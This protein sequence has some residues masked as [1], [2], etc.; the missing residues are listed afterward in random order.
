MSG[1]FT[2]SA[3]DLNGHTPAELASAASRAVESVGFGDG[4]FLLDPIPRVIEADDWTR[5]AAGLTQRVRALDAWCADVY[6]E[7]RI[8]RDGVVPARVTGHPRKNAS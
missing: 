3:P 2:E 4:P 7:R 6:G 5:L 8:V 1:P